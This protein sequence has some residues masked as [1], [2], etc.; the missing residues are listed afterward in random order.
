[1]RHLWTLPLLSKHWEVGR[2]QPSQQALSLRFC[3]DCLFRCDQLRWMVVASA[4][5]FL[6]VKLLEIRRKLFVFGDPRLPSWFRICLRGIPRKIPFRSEHHCAAKVILVDG[7]KNWASEKQ[8]VCFVLVRV[9]ANWM[10]FCE[11]KIATQ[12]EVLASTAVLLVTGSF[13]GGRVTQP[14]GNFMFIK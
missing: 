3:F 6:C 13:R 8:T 1:M 7:E 9:F 12:L 10:C 2:S 11:L 14:A 5:V 4:F